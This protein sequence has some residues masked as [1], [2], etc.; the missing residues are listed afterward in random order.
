[1]VKARSKIFV[2]ESRKSP[3]CLINCHFHCDDSKIVDTG[4]SQSDKSPI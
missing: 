4:L 3:H 2:P 1:L